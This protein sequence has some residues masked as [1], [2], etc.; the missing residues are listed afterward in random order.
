[1]LCFFERTLIFFSINEN[2]VHKNSSLSE[3]CQ[4]TTVLQSD[5]VR[6]PHYI[7]KLKNQSPEQAVSRRESLPYTQPNWTL[8]YHNKLFENPEKDGNQNTQRAGKKTKKTKNN[9][10]SQQVYF[11]LTDLR[12]DNAGPL[13]R[14]GQ[15]R[16]AGSQSV[17][18]MAHLEREVRPLRLQDVKQAVEPV[19]FS[20]SPC[21]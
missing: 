3:R 18:S 2:G 14:L 5:H 11:Y 9:K 19:M 21:V 15:D 1:M 4:S 8:Y 12:L 17:E 20:I 10:C 13:P 6:A 7:P 16:Q